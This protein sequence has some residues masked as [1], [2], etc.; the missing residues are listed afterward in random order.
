MATKNP[1]AA[2]DPIDDMDDLLIQLQEFENHLRQGRNLN[3][4]AFRQEYDMFSKYL[5]W[6]IE[7]FNRATRQELNAHIK[8][9][10]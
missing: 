8:G 7:D 5:K 10:G 1:A 2:H 3:S 6:R 4:P 9:L